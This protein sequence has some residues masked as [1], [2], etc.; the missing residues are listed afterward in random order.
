MKKTSLDDLPVQA[1]S[2]NRDIRKRVMIGNLAVP[3]L[4]GFSQAVF[5]AG[6]VA[7]G[8]VHEDMYEVFFVHRGRGVILV[9]GVEH[10]MSL[11]ECIMVEPGE[12]H[13]ISNPYPDELVLL[14]FG[15][16]SND[17]EVQ[18]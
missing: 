16:R 3:G 4:T 15:F 1:V 10:S 14:Y 7:P 9:D 6:Q 2:H 17:A 12:H 11:D 5:T 13:E 18:S 8:H